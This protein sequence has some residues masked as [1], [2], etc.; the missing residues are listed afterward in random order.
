MLTMV[1][2]DDDDG[3]DDG[4]SNDDGVWSGCTGS[5]MGGGG[6]GGILARWLW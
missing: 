4:D 6:C 2:D 5:W 1:D 3:D